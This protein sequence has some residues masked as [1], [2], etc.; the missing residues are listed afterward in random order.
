MLKFI[1]FLIELF[2]ETSDNKELY[3]KMKKT[4]KNE[5]DNC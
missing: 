5:K 3:R 1:K 4:Q 2:R